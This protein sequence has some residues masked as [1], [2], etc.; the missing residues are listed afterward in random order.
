MSYE[1]RPAEGPVCPK[2]E[3][4]AT[5]QRGLRACTTSGP[6]PWLASQPAREFSTRASARSPRRASSPPPPA[7]AAPGRG[8]ARR[9]HGGGGV[10]LAPQLLPEG[11]EPAPRVIE[12][13]RDP[14]L[15]PA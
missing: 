14:P 15:E 13:E 4:E 3:R 10:A 7:G 9:D 5:R 6:S 8:V 12:G 11:Q 2:P 1:A